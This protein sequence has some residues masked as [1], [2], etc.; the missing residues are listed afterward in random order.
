[1]HVH[2]FL[3]AVGS[4]VSAAPRG[5]SPCWGGCRM[6]STM[7]L[8]WRVSSAAGSGAFGV[9]PDLQCLFSAPHT[10]PC[11]N[12]S[13]VV[14]QAFYPFKEQTGGEWIVTYTEL[15]WSFSENFII[16]LINLG[17]PRRQNQKI[18]H[19][20]IILKHTQKICI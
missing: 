18:F 10:F 9:I 1:M 7:P 11:E 4:Q 20:R 8:G 3:G 19:R 13:Q 6:G 17:F 15:L 16:I 14:F 12:T 2:S 5:G